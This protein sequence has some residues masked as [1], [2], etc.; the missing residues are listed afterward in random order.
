MEEVIEA[1]YSD[2]LS[3]GILYIH[4]LKCA[5]CDSLH[6]SIFIDLSFC[7][8]HKTYN[9]KTGELWLYRN[10]T[11][12]RT[13]FCIFFQSLMAFTIIQKL[14]YVKR[15]K[16]NESS[17]CSKRSM[18]DRQGKIL[19]WQ[20]CQCQQQPVDVGA[21][22]SAQISLNSGGLGL[23]DLDK[24]FINLQSTSLCNISYVQY[25]MFLLVCLRWLAA[26]KSVNWLVT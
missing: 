24:A 15:M 13:H 23:G 10:G 14:Q 4:F 17:V 6:Q 21:N 3:D 18:M 1:S 2:R 9:N 5:C 11:Q 25:I 20:L 16:C 22:R 8:F 19:N 7:R 26:V 12:S